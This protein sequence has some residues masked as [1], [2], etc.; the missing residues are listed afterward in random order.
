[1]TNADRAR[2]GRSCRAAVCRAQPTCQRSTRHGKSP[3]P[4][5]F[6]LCSPRGGAIDSICEE[7]EAPEVKQ[8]AVHTADVPKA[9]LEAP[10]EEQETGEAQ[11]VAQSGATEAMVEAAA[12]LELEDDEPPE[13]RSRLSAAGR[14][15]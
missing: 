10:E 13:V 6:A 3:Q 2:M 14:Q 11:E 4:M 1:M 8:P 7:T 15:P 12:A 5:C 9:L